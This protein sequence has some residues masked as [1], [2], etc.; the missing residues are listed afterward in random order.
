M[1]KE[2]HTTIINWITQV[3]ENLP[4]AYLPEQVPQLGDLDEL[5]TFLGSKKNKLWLW[6]AP[7]H[8]R[9]GILGWAIEDRSSETDEAIVGVN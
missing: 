8:F 6:T 2:H 5:Q 1:K 4:D 9:P 7:T 3:G